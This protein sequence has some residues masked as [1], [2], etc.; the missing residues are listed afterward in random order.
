[1][2]Q[3]PT[4]ALPENLTVAWNQPSIAMHQNPPVASEVTHQTLRSA[5]QSHER[6]LVNLTKL[7]IE[8]SLLSGQWTAPLLNEST[9]EL[10]NV[11]FDI[12]SISF[13]ESTQIYYNVIDIL[14]SLT[15]TG[16]G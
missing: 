12:E 15:K 2:S 6:E 7:H 5:A 13:I 10:V 11:Q 16:Q 4:V 3:N 8:A 1:M 14:I 9:K